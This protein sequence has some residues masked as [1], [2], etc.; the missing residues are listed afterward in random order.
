LFL[1]TI[2]DLGIRQFNKKSGE[3]KM[4]G[5]YVGILLPIIFGFYGIFALFGESAR[6]QAIWYILQMALVL[7]SPFVMLSIVHSRYLRSHEATLMEKLEVAKQA[8]AVAPQEGMN[9][10]V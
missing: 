3:V 9:L 8:L 10:K 1:W 6:S 7:Y 4:I 5:R 2:D